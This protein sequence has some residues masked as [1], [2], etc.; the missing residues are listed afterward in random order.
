MAKKPIKPRTKLIKPLLLD[1]ETTGLDPFR[2]E[3]YEISYG[4]IG[5]KQGTL[6]KANTM[7]LR[8]PMR[9]LLQRMMPL[10]IL[11]RWAHQ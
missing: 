11:I 5:T 9:L 1:I 3:I 2:H 6:G 7:F 8:P 10:P 4:E